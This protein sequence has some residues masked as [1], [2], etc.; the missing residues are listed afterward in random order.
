[1]KRALEFVVLTVITV[2]IAAMF[3]ACNSNAEVAGQY[4]MTSVSGLMNGVLR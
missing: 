1:M 4:E 2:V 3:F